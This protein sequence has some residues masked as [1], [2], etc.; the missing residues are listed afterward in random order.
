MRLP[1]SSFSRA[2]AQPEGA[3]LG[4]LRLDELRGIDLAVGGG[5][6]SARIDEVR[7]YVGD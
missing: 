2:A 1:F 7:W 6:G 3:P 4:G 5:A